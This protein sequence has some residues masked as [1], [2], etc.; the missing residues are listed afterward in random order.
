MQPLLL[1]AGAILLF[2]GTRKKMAPV[3]G[4]AKPATSPVA[5]PKTTAASVQTER[6]P[7]AAGPTATPVATARPASKPYTV[8]GGVARA[9]NAGALTLFKDLQ[10]A[11]NA[12]RPGME[13]PKQLAVDGVIGAATVNRYITVMGSPQ[14]ASTVADAALAGGAF[15]VRTRLLGKVDTAPRDTSDLAPVR[16]EVVQDFG[17][18]T[19]RIRP[20]S[21]GTSQSF[22]DS[23]FR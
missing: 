8:T 7:D 11:L 21:G 6:K 9:T 10:K 4:A 5:Q 13:P 12:A 1:L 18:S 20:A 2:I 15:A 23:T 22:G 16:G 3:A 14:T 17:D 19:V